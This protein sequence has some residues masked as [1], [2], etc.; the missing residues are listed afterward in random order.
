MKQRQRLSDIIDTLT[1]HVRLENTRPN[2]KAE[3][4]DHEKRIFPGRKSI[5]TTTDC[6][7][8]FLFGQRT[9]LLNSARSERGVSR[10]GSCLTCPAAQRPSRVI[11][12]LPRFLR[13]WLARIGGQLRFRSLCRGPQRARCRRRP[14]LDRS[15]EP[16]SVYRSCNVDGARGHRQHGQNRRWEHCGSAC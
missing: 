12:V 14:F 13:A 3:P 2:W 16:E 7:T 1:A 9:I 10:C 11:L 8:D 6:R 15:E 4:R 5:S